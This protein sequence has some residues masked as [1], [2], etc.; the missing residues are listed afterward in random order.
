MLQGGRSR[1]RVPKR[2]LDFFNLP[3]PSSRIMALGSTQPRNEYHKS[4]W[5]VKGGRSVRLTTLSPS[6]SRLSI[7]DVGASNSHNRM[8]L[9]GLLQG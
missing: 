6:V 7:Q 5:G 9:H 1:V 4:S 3:N 8:D 2:S